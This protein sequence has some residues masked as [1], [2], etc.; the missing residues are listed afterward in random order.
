MN[1]QLAFCVFIG[2]L[3]AVSSSTQESFKIHDGKKFTSSSVTDTVHGSHACAV[4]CW[5]S[6]SCKGFNFR[7]TT[8]ASGECQLVT[9][10][11]NGPGEPL[12][13]E[14]WTYFESRY[15]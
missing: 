10:A 7:A 11:D 12:P 15:V 6:E 8:L 1:Y 5:D 2:L 14:G 9:N 4:L 13:L 3:S